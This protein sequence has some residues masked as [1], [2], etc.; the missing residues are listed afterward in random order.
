[1]SSNGTQ[2]HPLPLQLLVE[3]ADDQ[4]DLNHW[5]DIAIMLVHLLSLH[6]FLPNRGVVLGQMVTL[7]AC[8]DSPLWATE[9]AES[10]TGIEALFVVLAEDYG[11]DE[12]PVQ[13]DMCAGQE[14]AWAVLAALSKHM[15]SNAPSDE[16]AIL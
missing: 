2:P 11:F 7:L 1:M 4:K 13:E 3:H 9:L 14:A 16:V 10:I 15:V 5:G 12:V 6:E 8:L